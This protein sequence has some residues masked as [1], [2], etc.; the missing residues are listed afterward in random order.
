MSNEDP[1]HYLN[2]SDS[3]HIEQMVQDFFMA[4]TRPV[5]NHEEWLLRVAATLMEREAQMISMST[6]RGGRGKGRHG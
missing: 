6:Q 3:D 1:E 5:N 2:A 4:P